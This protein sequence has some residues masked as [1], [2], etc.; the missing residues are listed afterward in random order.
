MV[1][2]ITFR[3]RILSAAPRWLQGFWGSRLLYAIGVV[4][5][6]LIDWASYAVHLRYASWC[7]SHLPDALAMHGRNRGIVRGFEE[8]AVPYAARLQ[9]WI[10]DRK[11]KGNLY[12]TM[13]Q[14]AGY[15]T[16]YDVTIRCV[17]LNGAW[18]TR[19]PDGTRE[20]HRA[21]PSNWNWDPHTDEWSRYW[22]IIYPPI[23]LWVDEGYFDSD[24]YFGDGGQIGSTITQDQA[25]SLRAI[26]LAWNPPHACPSHI[27]LALDSESFDPAGAPGAPL[28]TVDWET[29]ADYD[30]SDNAYSTRL[31]TGR[32]C[33]GI[34]P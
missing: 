8:P 31:D 12:T 16:R 21:S 20:Y 23:D 19:L 5:D 9:R 25:D 28:P 2:L 14:L 33:T 34:D 11:R 18:L 4:F 15:L 26:V 13:D 6:A 32:Y 17:N 7:A 3:S 22:V 30:G 1:D 27:I 10:Q 29:W 24:E